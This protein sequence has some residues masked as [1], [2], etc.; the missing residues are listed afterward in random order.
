MAHSERVPPHTVRVRTGGFVAAS[1]AGLMP[2]SSAIVSPFK[3][4][5]GHGHYRRREAAPA[6]LR[7]SFTVWDVA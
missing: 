6:V 2:S 1:Y 3:H 5:G 7:P 4:H